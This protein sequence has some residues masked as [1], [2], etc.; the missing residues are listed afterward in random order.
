V[1]RPPHLFAREIEQIGIPTFHLVVSG[2]REVVYDTV[3]GKPYSSQL[4]DSVESLRQSWE[5]HV[6]GQK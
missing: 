6:G 5:A 2:T 3:S 1:C 4:P